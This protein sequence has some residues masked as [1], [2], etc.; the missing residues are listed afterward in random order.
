MSNFCRND[1]IIEPTSFVLKLFFPPKIKKGGRTK[2]LHA[3]LLPE[4]PS[5]PILEI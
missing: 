3:S 5:S 1:R 2:Y 4:M